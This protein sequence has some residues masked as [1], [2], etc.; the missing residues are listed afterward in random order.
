ML[1]CTNSMTF[2]TLMLEFIKNNKGLFFTY[3]LLL[4]VQP[5]R[6]V[7]MP[8]MVGKLYTTIKKNK[9]L[10]GILL[11]IIGL[12]IVIQVLY[13]VGDYVEIKLYPIL[14]KF[15]RESMMAHIFST[16]ETNYNDIEIGAIITKIIKLPSIMYNYVDQ[17]RSSYIPGIITLIFATCYFIWVDKILGLSLLVILIVFAYNL[18]R[19]FYTCKD[20]A[21][22][23]EETFS[24]MFGD[25][26]DV[27]RN[28][29]TIMS[30]N[31]IDD[32]F[33]R[34]DE[35]QKIYTDYTENTFK[36]SLTPKYII[37]PLM[38][39]YVVFMCLYCYR[40][41][42]SSNLETGTFISLLIIIFV[43]MGVVFSMLSSCKELYMRWGVIQSSLQVFE[44]CQSLRIPYNLP[45]NIDTGIQ[46][47]DIVYQYNSKTDQRKVFDGLNLNLRFNEITLI[48]GE[49]G[50]GKSTLIN[51]LLKYQIP[52]SGEIFLNGVPYKDI[53]HHKLRQ[54]IVYLPQS[55][56]LLNRT[57]YEN[58]VYGLGKTVTKEAVESVMKDLGLQGFLEGLP[59]GIDSPTGV[60]GSRLS[61]GQRQIVWIIKAVLLNPQIIVMDEPTASV[62]DSTKSTIHYL[63]EK[64][65]SGR[66]VIMITHDPYLLRFANRVITLDDGKVI[67]DEIITKQKIFEPPYK[68]FR[69]N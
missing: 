11:T 37:I 2:Q 50:S 39:S 59:K 21:L 47:Q 5:V 4:L 7:L 28:M 23:R 14:N 3:L 1:E 24:T 51:L 16:R 27:L 6:D 68:K 54:T 49:I 34:L 57:V 45:A 32:E 60:H 15:I 56:I 53:D 63:L 38:L 13:V 46:I 10:N 65:M 55:P 36:C 40:N 17:W 64:V 30:F 12:V 66:T 42:K 25:V 69:K 35:Y 43:V 20:L 31:K 22:K 9:P 44:Q 58:I 19:S 52:E 41:V 8:H 67:G 62:D 29:M 33:Q 26:D 18:Y 48:V 61:G